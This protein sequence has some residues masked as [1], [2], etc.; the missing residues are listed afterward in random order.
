MESSWN[1]RCRK[2]QDIYIMLQLLYLF[3]VLYSESLLGDRFVRIHQRYLVN[4]PEVERI[5]NK[6][7]VIHGKAVPVSKSRYQEVA[8]RFARMMLEM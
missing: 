6:C 2:G 5:D 3:L 1:R 8:G 4:L 7:A